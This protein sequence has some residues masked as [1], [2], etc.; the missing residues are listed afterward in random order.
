MPTIL[1]SL[2]VNFTNRA[3]L[4]VFFCQNLADGLLGALKID[5]KAGVE[6]HDGHGAIEKSGRLSD[7]LIAGAG[8]WFHRPNCFRHC[9]NNAR[10]D[11]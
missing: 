11:T 8:G 1:E 3:G 5:G 2:L 6:F 10:L 7:T 4:V 9:S